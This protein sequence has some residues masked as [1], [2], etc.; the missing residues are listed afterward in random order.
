MNRF[1]VMDD[2]P[3]PD[4]WGDI[5]ERAQADAL[6][7]LEPDAPRRRIGRNVPAVAIAAS[8]LAVVAAVGL[9]IDHD[10]RTD[11]ATTETSVAE[12]PTDPAT[13]DPSFAG[14]DTQPVL[15][16]AGGELAAGSMPDDAAFGGQSVSDVDQWAAL[17]AVATWSWLER[18]NDVQVIVPGIGRVV[19]PEFLAPR[20]EEIDEAYSDLSGTISH[21]TADDGRPAVVLTLRTGLEAPCDWAEVRVA[22]G[23]EAERTA[24]AMRVATGLEW[25]ERPIVTEPEGVV[26]GSTMRAFTLFN[27]A[28]QVPDGTHAAELFVDRRFSQDGVGG[29]AY[30]GNPALE[31]QWVWSG[32]LR[33]PGV[34]DDHDTVVTTNVG[35]TGEWFSSSGSYPA[36]VTDR[37]EMV[38][39]RA[40][41]VGASEE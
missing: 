25:V 34:P 33:V 8:V 39:I 21:S 36:G 15:A 41:I 17:G 5:V 29:R 18:Q 11:V 28:R 10:R 3:V 13:E 31:P 30:M 20:T 12:P 2:V 1:D 22:G 4:Q 35:D 14:E 37:A 32:L 16:C 6:I 27:A 38:P 23:S 9:V 26:D 24:L 7:E 40:L 19:A